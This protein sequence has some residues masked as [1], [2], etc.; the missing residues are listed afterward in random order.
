ML[1]VLVVLTAVSTVQSASLAACIYDGSSYRSGETVIF[2]CTECVCQSG[3]IKCPEKLIC[4]ASCHYQGTEHED[5]SRW[6]AGCNTCQCDNGVIICDEKQCPDRCNVDMGM[7]IKKNDTFKRGCN[8]CTCEG[9][10]NISCTKKICSCFDNNGGE[11]ENGDF[12]KDEN[13]NQ[14]VCRDGEIECNSGN[15]CKKGCSINSIKLKDGQKTTIAGCLVFQCNDGNP[16]LVND[17]C[18]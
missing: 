18:G 4:P 7:T 9:N 14:C 11:L 17:I 8:T 13:C 10:D 6:R 2:S 1:C 5:G 3:K 12:Y 15:S 16:I